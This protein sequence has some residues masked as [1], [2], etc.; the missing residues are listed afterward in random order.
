MTETDSYYYTLKI[1]DELIAQNKNLDKIALQLEAQTRLQEGILKQLYLL[2]Q[3]TGKGSGGRYELAC[4]S[5]EAFMNTP[6]SEEKP[7]EANYDSLVK[8]YTNE[9]GEV[10]YFSES[11]DKFIKWILRNI[12]NFVKEEPEHEN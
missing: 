8:T 7:S 10:V 1:R 12:K 9:T 6:I 11:N 4:E 3:M 5:E 2:C